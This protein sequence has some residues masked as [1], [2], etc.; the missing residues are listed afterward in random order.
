M[1]DEPAGK[2]R[3]T[4]AL[5]ISAV[6]KEKVVEPAIETE[7]LPANVRVLVL[8]IPIPLPTVSGAD[9][10]MVVVPLITKAAHADATLT[11]GIVE[12]ADI[13]AISPAAGKP[14]EGVQLPL[15]FQLLFDEPVQV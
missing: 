15:L 10:V 5:I 4:P 12:V 6:L 3:V 1:T 7:L 2:V 11:V 8:L 9:K 13:N 14:T